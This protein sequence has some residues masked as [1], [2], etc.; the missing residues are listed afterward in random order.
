MYDYS[1]LRGRIVEVCGTQC[2]FAK[3]I[4]LSDR[5]VNL[6]I[7]GNVFWKQNEIDKAIEALNLTKDDIQSYFFVVKVQN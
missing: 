4:G 3:R 2:E 5:S 6:K 7:N 1:K